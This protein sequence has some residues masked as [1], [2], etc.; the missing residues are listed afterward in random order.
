[1]TGSI[2]PREFSNAPG[3]YGLYGRW[4]DIGRSGGGNKTGLGIRRHGW[5]DRR[6]RKDVRS[7]DF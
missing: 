4:Q 1:M 2:P 6:R 5:R 3:G 7:Q